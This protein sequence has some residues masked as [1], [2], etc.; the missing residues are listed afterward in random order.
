MGS[1][2]NLL[3]MLLPVSE[4]Y[5][6]N[7]DGIAQAL[8]HIL[9]SDALQPVAEY[10]IVHINSEYLDNTRPTDHDPAVTRLTLPSTLDISKTVDL[11]TTILPG[12]VVTYTITLSNLGFDRVYGVEFTDALPAGIT[13]GEWVEN[14]GAMHADG[15]ITWEGFV[16]ED[17]TFI[18]TAS[19]NLDVEYGSTIT[20]SASFEYMGGSGSDEVDLIVQTLNRLILPILLRNAVP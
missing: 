2:L 6:Y 9:V 8:D 3:T 10:D 18:F 17:L 13:F 1:E 11:P 15:L 4:R 16:V 7:Y 12:S 19:I 14:P 20:N 5:T